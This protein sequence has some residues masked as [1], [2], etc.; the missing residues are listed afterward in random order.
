MSKF[1][2]VVRDGKQYVAY[3]NTHSSTP[4]EVTRYWPVGSTMRSGGMF[5]PLEDLETDF[6]VRV[7]G[8]NFRSAGGWLI[9]LK[10][11]GKTKPDFSEERDIH[12]PK[13]KLKTEYRDGFWYKIMNS[14]KRV[15]AEGRRDEKVRSYGGG[16]VGG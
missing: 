7:D 2:H 15:K 12:P 11:G 9:V 3:T 8:G 1:R 4:V 13:T 10:D 6:E 16:E 14:G 5:R